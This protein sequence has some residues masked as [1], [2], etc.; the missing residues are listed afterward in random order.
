MTGTNKETE[1]PARRV[2]RNP[3]P[4]AI[5]A[6]FIVFIGAMATWI[7]YASRQPMDLV[8][9]D[10]YEKEILFQQQIDAANRARKAEGGVK[11]EYDFT[12]QSIIVQLP[13]AAG[14]GGAAGTIHFYRPND[15][16]L[17]HDLTLAVNASGAQTLDAKALAPGLWKVRLSWRLNGEEFYYDKS[18]VVG[19]NS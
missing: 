10:Y 19:S 16:R 1:A 6:Y 11:V 3:W 9:R 18:V 5:I 13:T 2:R 12:Q 4:I 15:A 7:A 17:D 8:R 14:Q